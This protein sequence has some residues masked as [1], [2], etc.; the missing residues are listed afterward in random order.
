MAV[1]RHRD[2]VRVGPDPTKPRLVNRDNCA[3]TS[4]GLKAGHSDAL[5]TKQYL[6]AEAKNYMGN[7][8]P[9]ILWHTVRA[10]VNWPEDLRKLNQQL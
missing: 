3:P 9:L 8:I 7:S 6:G 5:G 4:C 10:R 2:E 1:K